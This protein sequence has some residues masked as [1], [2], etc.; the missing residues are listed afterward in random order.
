MKRDKT[1]RIKPVEQIELEG[2]HI[3]LRIILAIVFFLI[4]VGSLVFILVTVNHTDAGWS[5]IPIQAGTIN[6]DKEI[7]VNYNLGK[8]GDA[9]TESRAIK[10]LASDT[11]E[12]SYKA[13]DAYNSYDEVRNIYYLNRNYNKD[14]V[15]SEFLYNSLSKAKDSNII[16]LGPL[17]TYYDSLMGALTDADSKAYDPLYS[18][19]IKT[20]FAEVLVYAK[21]RNHIHLEF[22]ADNT[23]NLVISAE[24]LEF[25]KSAGITDFINLSWLRNAFIVDAIA[26]RMASNNYL[27][28]YVTS[29][30][31]FTR[32]LGSAN[33]KFGINLIDYDTKFIT[34]GRIEYS[35]AYSV[36]VMKNF[37]TSSY[38]Q[39]Y[40]RYIDNNRRT[41]YIDQADGISK[42]ASNYFVSIANNKSVVD[43]AIKSAEI[44]INK[45]LN[46]TAID[47]SSYYIVSGK[48]VLHNTDKFT[49][50]LSEGYEG[51]TI[52][53]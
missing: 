18:E 11:L 23:I 8:N 22:K 38:D 14:L 26:D 37:M 46:L 45:E 15:V 21:D 2:R 39:K 25:A 41:Y 44:N 13:L 29:A 6:A 4:F 16:F 28:G 3:K 49:L 36:V 35:G 30:D 32:N 5:S 24:Y 17:V 43:L 48:K 52:N 20:L 51:E 34:V 47:D 1:D 7:A 12:T 27:N 10:A 53:A 40:I 31:G 50:V 9:G 33:E 42:V 19:T